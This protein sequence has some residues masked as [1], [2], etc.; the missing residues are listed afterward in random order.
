MAFYLSQTAPEIQVLLTKLE[1]FDDETIVS[2]SAELTLNQCSGGL[3]NNYGQTDDSNIELITA[4][5]NSKLIFI[6]GTT[7]AKYL[8]FV[9]KAG[10][11]IYLEGV[12]TGDGKYVGLASVTRGDT[13][14]FI[15]YQTGESSYDWYAMPGVGAWTAQP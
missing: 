2:S 1:N 6:A 13:I 15:S 9:P 14:Q 8:R 4:V 11:S 3:I 10:D 7:V 5:K 12:T